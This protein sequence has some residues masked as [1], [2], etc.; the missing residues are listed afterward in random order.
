MCGIAGIVSTENL[1]PTL[2]ESMTHAISHRGPDGLGHVRLEGCHLGHARLSVI[3]LVGGSQPM[4]DAAQ[5][6]WVVFNGEI[7]NWSD[8][9]NQLEQS[10]WCFRTRSDTEVLLVAYIH[11][12]SKVVEQLNG[13]F[14]FAIWDSVEQRLFA[15]RDR[16]GEKP[17]YYAPLGNSGMMFASELRGILATSLIEPRLDLVSVDAYLG[18]YYVPPDRCIYEN[19]HTLPPAHTLI[20]EGGSLRIVRY[21]R[22]EMSS[23][24]AV[25]SREVVSTVRLLLDS[26]VRRQ[27]VSDVPIGAFLSGGLDSATVVALMSQ[28]SDRPIRTFSLG[29]GD[30]IDE[31]PH[32][33]QVATAYG[34]DH[35]EIQAPAPSIELLE[36]ISRAYDEPL[37][38]SSSV[39]TFCLARTV[40][41]HVTVALTGD[42]GDEIFGGYEWYAPWIGR[43]ADRAGLAEILAHRVMLW[44]AMVLQ[45]L[46]LMTSASVGRMGMEHQAKLVSRQFDD[47]FHRHICLAGKWL[48][49]RSSL[50]GSSRLRVMTSDVIARYKPPT[51]V[52]GLDRA[53]WFDI[54]TYLPGDIL[55]KVDRA[56]MSHGLESRAPFLDR[57]LTNYVLALPESIRFVPARLKS[58]LYEACADLWPKKIRNRKK[59]GFGAPVAQWMRHPAL[60]ALWERLTASESAL[61]TL[62]PGIRE[63]R[64]ICRLGAQQRWALL[65]LGLWLERR[66]ACL[67]TLS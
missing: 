36:Q 31:L 6:Y 65:Q 47:I 21:W 12:G 54:S 34:S 9:R 56:T 38:D 35:R 53:T 24:R 4:T 23:S 7:F 41:Q 33:R 8:L 18:L 62:L 37:G 17:F 5:R 3:D 2:I 64:A 45:K 49:D 13:Q 50:W 67:R 60:V 29:F 43:T 10:G 16:F 55:M 25:A 15:A 51:N 27:M 57:E 28:H 63:E 42:G 26:A 48:E 58:L 1:N 40:K 19:I 30:A 14:A 32:A 20:F 44:T 46:K 61:A 66:S 52:A 11:Y 39:P 22:P 59:Q